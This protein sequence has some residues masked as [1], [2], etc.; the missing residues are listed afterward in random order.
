MAKAIRQPLEEI[1]LSMKGFGRV[2]VTGCGGCSSVCLAGGQRETLELADELG[3]L[4]RGRGEGQRRF[5]SLV[6]ERQCNPLFLEKRA[7]RA[8]VS[9]CILSLACGA[10]VQAVADRYHSLP[11]FP[12][13]DPLFVGVDLD[14]GD[15]HPCAWVEIHDRLKDQGRLASILTVRPPMEWTDKGPAILE[16]GHF[17]QMICRDR[18]RIAMEADILGAA[19]M[20]RF[21]AANLP[22]PVV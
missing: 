10:G 9:D 13:L 19:A 17:M 8:T 7:G 1:F 14:V 2:L 18:N 22:G 15:G 16:A 11:V 5:A 12:A 4:S 20:V 3:D 6:I 21:M